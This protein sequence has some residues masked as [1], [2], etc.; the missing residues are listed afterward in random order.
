MCLKFGMSNGYKYAKH[1]IPQ[2]HALRLC[3]QQILPRRNE[4]RMQQVKMRF[5]KK[6]R[7][8]SEFRSHKVSTIEK[9]PSEPASFSKETKQQ[10]VYP[11]TPPKNIPK[12]E[13]VSYN[14]LH[15]SRAPAHRL[16]SRM[17]LQGAP[18]PPP[19][20][21]QIEQFSHPLRFLLV[22]KLSCELPQ[23]PPHQHQSPHRKIPYLG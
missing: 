16:S 3:L 9:Q 15:R 6:E 22:F 18:P 11:M 1:V 23:S 7:K 8:H 21:L 2:E 10:M 13:I 19:R 12:P 17:L 4:V 14:A 20:S 5:P